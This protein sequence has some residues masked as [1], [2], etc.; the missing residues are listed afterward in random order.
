MSTMS[1]VQDADTDGGGSF[2]EPAVNGHG[3]RR[4]MYDGLDAGVRMQGISYIALI[5]ATR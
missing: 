3:Q 4:F 1:P 2:L 5:L